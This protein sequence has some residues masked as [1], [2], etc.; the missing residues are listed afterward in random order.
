MVHWSKCTN[1]QPV[2]NSSGPVVPCKDSLNELFKH[3]IVFKNIQNSTNVTAKIYLV[4][5]ILVALPVMD[6]RA[7]TLWRFEVRVPDVPPGSSLTVTHTLFQT[8][9]RVVQKMES[10]IHRI[11]IRETNCVIQWI[12]RFARLS[13]LTF[14]SCTWFASPL[15]CLRE[16]FFHECLRTFYYLVLWHKTV[17]SELKAETNTFTLPHG[18]PENHTRFHTIV[19]K[20]YTCFQTKTF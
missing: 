1:F 5:I 10:A 20:A 11:S 17:F 14:K 4:G 9:R 8:W 15:S 16:C 7:G 2:K 19:D 18:S 3:D 6:A 12:A 13:Y